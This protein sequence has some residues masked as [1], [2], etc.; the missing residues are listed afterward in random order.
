MSRH[1]FRI[2][3]SEAKILT[4]T[5]GYDRP[6]NCVFCTV[7]R[8]GEEDSPLYSNLDDEQAGLD[9]QDV[10]YFRDALAQLGIQ[11]PEQM[12]LEVEWDQITRTGNRDVDHTS[13]T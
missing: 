8:E 4:V 11:I 5:L 1:Q 9:Q 13:S 12:F 7:F 2:Y 6:L 10:N 3:D